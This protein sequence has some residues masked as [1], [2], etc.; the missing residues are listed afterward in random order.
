MNARGHHSCWF[1]APISTAPS[2]RAVPRRCAGARIVIAVQAWAEQVKSTE[3]IAEM[4]IRLAGLD[5][6]PPAAPPGSEARSRRTAELVADLVEAAPRRPA[7]RRRWTAE[8]GST[9]RPLRRAARLAAG[10]HEAQ[11]LYGLIRP[12]A[13]SVERAGSSNGGVV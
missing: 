10:G 13:M 8:G 5:G 2:G 6:V 9:D 11:T 12:L 4:A 1:P 3:I 7:I